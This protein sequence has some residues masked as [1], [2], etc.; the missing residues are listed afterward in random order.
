MK[1]LNGFKKIALEKISFEQ[2]L[3]QNLKVPVV[4]QTKFQKTVL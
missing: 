4:R 2:E 1:N 3:D